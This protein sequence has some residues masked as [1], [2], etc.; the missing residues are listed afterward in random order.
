MFY[1]SE[2]I[3]NGDIIAQEIIKIE[4]NDYVKDIMYKIKKSTFDILKAH[5]H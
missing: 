1:L 2:G 3:D 5:F 4:Q